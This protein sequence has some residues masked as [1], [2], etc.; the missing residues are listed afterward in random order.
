MQQSKRHTASILN[1][2]PIRIGKEAHQGNASLFPVHAT[3]TPGCCLPLGRIVGYSTQHHVLEVHFTTD[4][5]STC[6]QAAGLYSTST[7][8]TVPVKPRLARTVTKHGT[9]V[10]CLEA[11]VEAAR[12]C[13]K[14]RHS[15]GD[16]TLCFVSA[17][18]TASNKDDMFSMPRIS[19]LPTCM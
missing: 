9:I 5:P 1:Y 15:S 14:R 10:T 17:S 7:H 11:E 18:S 13:S 2:L 16:R 8:G 3:S 6:R 19:P 4:P 12:Y